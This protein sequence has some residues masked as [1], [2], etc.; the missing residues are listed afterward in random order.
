MQTNTCI[1]LQI[2]TFYYHGNLITYYIGNNISGSIPNHLQAVQ[3]P[4]ISYHSC[5]EDYSIIK[6]H[7]KYGMICAGYAEGGKDTCQVSTLGEFVILIDNWYVRKER[8]IGLK[9][10][11]LKLIHCREILVAQW[12]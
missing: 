3:V 4:Y 8:N 12:S 6:P 2:G 5:R 7:L 10:I 11:Q 9:K 1:S